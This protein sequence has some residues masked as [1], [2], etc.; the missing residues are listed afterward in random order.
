MLLPTETETAEAWSWWPLMSLV[1]TLEIFLAA[2]V[3]ASIGWGL[4]LRK[5]KPHLSLEQSISCRWSNNDAFIVTLILRY[6]NTSTYRNIAV[7][8]ISVALK[9]LAPLL[10]A[11][12]EAAYDQLPDLLLEPIPTR[13]RDKSRAPILDPGE[14]ATESF[15]YLVPKDIAVT[16]RAFTV[17]TFIHETKNPKRGWATLTAHDVRQD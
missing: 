2:V 6:S 5:W 17:H 15:N 13:E 16:L 12:V 9:R 1:D 11:E 3:V 4:A 8:Q 14:S 10:P 7:T